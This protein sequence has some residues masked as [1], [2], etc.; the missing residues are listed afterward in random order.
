MALSDAT[1]TALV[2]LLVTT[3]LAVVLVSVYFLIQQDGVGTMLQVQVALALYITLLVA[4]G[5]FTERLLTT[6]FQ[7]ALALGLAAWGVYLYSVDGSIIGAVLAVAGLLYL[8]SQGREL[9]SAR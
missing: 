8:G 6:G 7:T 3:L 5:V 4:V 2:K 1:V 9:L